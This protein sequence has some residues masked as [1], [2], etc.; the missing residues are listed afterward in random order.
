MDPPLVFD[1]ELSYREGHIID[2]LLAVLRVDSQSCPRIPGSLLVADVVIGLII[3]QLQVEMHQKLAELLL[4]L[5]SIVGFQASYE[6]KNIKEVRVPRGGR[7][8]SL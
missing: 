7:G 1:R 4:N 5:G 3:Q 8:T 6:K 2:E